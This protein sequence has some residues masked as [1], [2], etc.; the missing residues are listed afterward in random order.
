MEELT[1]SNNSGEKKVCVS[2]NTN[3]AKCKQSV[4]LGEW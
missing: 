2:A 4:N 1:F 3:G